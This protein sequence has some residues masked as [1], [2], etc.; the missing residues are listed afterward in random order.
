MRTYAD[1]DVADVA[2]HIVIVVEH[3][4]RRY[5]LVVHQPQRITQRLVS[6]DGEHLLRSDVQVL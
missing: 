4:Q 1:V 5:R 3:G 6:V 2:D